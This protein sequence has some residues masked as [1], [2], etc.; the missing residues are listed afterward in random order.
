MPFKL[1]PYLTLNE[2]V[3]REISS[4]VPKEVAEHRIA[5]LVEHE[6]E[7]DRIRET[8]RPLTAWGR[9][10]LEKLLAENEQEFQTAETARRSEE[11]RSIQEA[12]A[13]RE[14]AAREAEHERYVT[15]HTAPHL[16]MEERAALDAEIRERN[17][18]PEEKS[19]PVCRRSVA[20]ID[21]Q[22]PR[23][24][25]ITVR[26]EFHQLETRVCLPYG[27]EEPPRIQPRVEIAEPDFSAMQKRM[28]TWRYP[29]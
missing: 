1:S 5:R 28:P 17:A 24:H 22:L 6:A 16:S 18:N 10:D 7:L 25:K 15:Q 8:N 27:L 23:E 11:M 21:G 29:S 9:V 2:Q 13:A 19:C 20:L 14:A 4:G 12:K 3:N 26:N